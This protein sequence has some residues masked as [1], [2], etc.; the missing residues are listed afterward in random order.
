MRGMS[1]GCD[2]SCAPCGRLVDPARWE[3]VLALIEGA[4][5][6][7]LSGHTN[8]DG[9]ALG[10]ALG[11]GLAIRGAFPGKEVSFLLADDAPVPRILKFLPHV[12]EFVYASAF[13]GT[14]DLFIAVDAPSLDR[15]ENSAAVARRAGARVVIDHHPADCEYADAVVRNPRAAAAAM[16][17]LDLLEVKGL[18]VTAEVADCLYTGLVTDTGRFQYQNADAAAFSSAAHLVAAGAD[19]ARVSLEVYQSQRIEYLRLEALVVSRIRMTAG[20]KVAYSYSTNADLEEYGVGFDECE[21]LIDLVR[22]VAGV[23]VCLFAKEGRSPGFVRGN[24]RSKYG[25]D[26][27]KVAARFNGGGHASAAGFS[28]RGTVEE[29]L[30]AVVP[31]LVELVESGVVSDSGEW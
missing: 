7:A 16:L 14:P 6:I 25:H 2:A 23:E 30:A 3:P 10:T 8:P 18:E 20:G 15:L 17:V 1:S 24:L 11:L 5:S 22:Q 19:P 21:G 26:V 9:D 31:C 12:D 28:W 29:A 4:Q 13:Q 27:S